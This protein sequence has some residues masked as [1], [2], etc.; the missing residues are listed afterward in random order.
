M[1]K[2]LPMLRELFRRFPRHFLGLLVLIFIQGGLNAVS[3]VAVAPITDLLLKQPDDEVNQI[4]KVF[5]DLLTYVG[6]DFNI[7]VVFIFF[8]LVMI[9]NGIAGVATVYATARI[10]FDVVHDISFLAKEK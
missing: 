4:T 8:A 7:V 6:F 10:K 9:V 2:M 1:N 3:I 5:E